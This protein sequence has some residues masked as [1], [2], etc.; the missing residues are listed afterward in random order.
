MVLCQ[1]T[2]INTSILDSLCLNKTHFLSGKVSESQMD[3]MEHKDWEEKQ[4]MKT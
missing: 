2:T 1:C 3:G 4:K